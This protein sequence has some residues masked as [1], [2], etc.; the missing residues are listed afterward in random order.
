VLSGKVVNIPD[1]PNSA[2]LQYPEEARHEGIQSMLSAPLVGKDGP[3]G[4]IR[5]YAVESSRF[6][7]EDEAFLEAIAAQGSIAIENA[8]AYH[9]VEA[10]DAAK[11]HFI[12]IV[13]HELRS[14]VSV[15][16][17]LLRNI[18]AGYAG[19]VSEQQLDILNRA[20]R[21]VEF[22]QKLIDDLLDLAAAKSEVK[23]HEKLEPVNVE[24]AVQRVVKR[25]EVP[26][27]D[28]GVTLEWIDGS[29]ARQEGAQAERESLAD[30]PP[31]GAAA[32]MATPDGLDQVLNNLVS[33]AV[34]YTPSGG[35]VTVT[36][37]QSGG[38]CLISVRDTG[39]GIP[40][41][42]R[43]HLFE[44]FFRA[45]NAKAIELQGTGLGLTIVKDLIARFGGRLSFQSALNAGSEFTISLPVAKHG[46]GSAQSQ[47]DDYRL[48]GEHPGDIRN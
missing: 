32:V 48:T 10:L 6:T 18:V 35:R 47:A 38:D 21:R 8:M 17:S 43:E 27:A 5:A 30:L 29:K 13:T 2:L 40:E 42:A 20:S 23:T 22:L 16:Q 44:E 15:T 34:K 3:L 46:A 11:S 4:V 33:N 26:A 28:K 39:I 9:A 12:R 45:P 37:T 36:S 19:Q 31:G 41:D 14:P 24:A 25:F 7:P 1:A